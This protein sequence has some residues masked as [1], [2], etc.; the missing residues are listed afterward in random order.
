MISR[1]HSAILQSVDAIPRGQVGCEVEA[2]VAHGGQGEMR[3]DGQHNIPICGL[4]IPAGET[5]YVGRFQS[6]PTYPAARSVISPNCPGAIGPAVGLSNL[7]LARVRIGY[8]T[9]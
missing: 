9:V 5:V 1:V 2:D 6:P 7:I 4:A 3:N 8:H